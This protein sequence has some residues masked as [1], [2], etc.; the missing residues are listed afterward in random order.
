M[1]SI[2][3]RESAAEQVQVRCRPLRLSEDEVMRLMAVIRPDDYWDA[4]R[5]QVTVCRLSEE[6]DPRGAEFG[7]NVWIHE[8]NGSMRTLRI[9][10]MRHEVEAIDSLLHSYAG[11]YGF[12]LIRIDERSQYVSKA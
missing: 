3:G 1:K 11:G 4:L 9:A 6:I 8:L 12:S 7:V 2:S 5:V 10:A